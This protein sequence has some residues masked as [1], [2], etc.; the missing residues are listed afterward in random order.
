M[1]GF[2]MICPMPCASLCVPELN[3]GHG[4]GFFT[5]Y[6]A[7]SH[8]PPCRPLSTLGVLWSSYLPQVLGPTG[9]V[10]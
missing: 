3:L 5:P 1:P 9:Q 7:W 8:F 4:D 10:G 2:R 6:H